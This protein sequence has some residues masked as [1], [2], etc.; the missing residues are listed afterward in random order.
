MNC[1]ILD[2][3]HLFGARVAAPRGC[4]TTHRGEPRQQIGIGDVLLFG[5]ELIPQRPS[6]GEP[7]PGGDL[8]Q[9]VE[10]WIDS[11][12]HRTETGELHDGGVDGC[13][14]LAIDVGHVPEGRGLG[15]AQ[16]GDP[17]VETGQTVSVG[18][19]ERGPVP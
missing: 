4:S 13:G 8:Q 6:A 1:R 11:L 17:V 18:G 19:R 15:D 2:P 9:I 5:A 14:D 7:Q 10:S 12:D 16:A 3:A